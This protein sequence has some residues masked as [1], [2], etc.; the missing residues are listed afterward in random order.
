MA[1]IRIN[2]G[3]YSEQMYRK[4]KVLHRY[5]LVNNHVTQRGKDIIRLIPKK[6]NR[7]TLFSANRA[8][9]KINGIDKGRQ[10]QTIND[11]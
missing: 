4:L 5:L 2:L 9:I 6:P 1:T 3:T 11:F 10:M 7:I 8:I